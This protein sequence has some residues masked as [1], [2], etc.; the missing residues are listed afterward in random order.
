MARAEPPY[1]SA[2]AEFVRSIS[3]GTIACPAV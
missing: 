1:S 3:A 2:F